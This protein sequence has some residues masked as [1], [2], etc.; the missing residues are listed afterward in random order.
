MRNCRYLE[1]KKEVI[2]M[3]ETNSYPANVATED[4]FPKV[5]EMKSITFY[6]KKIN[7]LFRYRCRY[8]VTRNLKKDKS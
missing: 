6:E 3:I 5:R 4:L 8:W 1:Y 7:E 2:K